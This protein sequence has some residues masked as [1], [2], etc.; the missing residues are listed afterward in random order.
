MKKEKDLFAWKHPHWT[1]QLLPLVIEVGIFYLCF[2]DTFPREHGVVAQISLAELAIGIVTVIL[3]YYTCVATMHR[4]GQVRNGVLATVHVFGENTANPLAAHYAI[5]RIFRQ[6]VSNVKIQR[7]VQCTGNIWVMKNI[8]LP[9]YSLRNFVLWL[10]GDIFIKTPAGIFPASRIETVDEIRCVV[11]TFDILEGD[12]RRSR[13]IVLTEEGG[14]PVF[15]ESESSLKGIRL[16]NEPPHE[17]RFFPK[18]AI[19][20]NKR[21]SLFV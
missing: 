8:K 12:T 16:I 7:K 18:P 1:L 15:V 3:F 19:E 11:I 10:K 13:E 17:K 21:K 6:T 4:L 5:N 9:R 2:I 20:E 14:L